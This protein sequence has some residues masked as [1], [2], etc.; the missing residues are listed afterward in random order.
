MGYLLT[1]LLK[2]GQNLIM[3]SGMHQVFSVGGI[4][5]LGFPTILGTS[6]YVLA[7]AERAGISPLVAFLLGVISALITGFFMAYLYA[8]MSNDSFV[9]LGLSSIIAFKA[10][11]LSGGE[12]TN[13]A[14]GIKGVLR[15][16]FMEKLLPLAIA[17]LIV[18]G[19]FWIIEYGIMSSWIGRAFRA[20]KED[21]RAVEA[22][23]ISRKKIDYFLI[24]YSSVLFSIGG[25]FML[26]HIQFLDPDFAHLELMIQLLT[27]GILALKPQLRYL[28][29]GV[30]FV[31]FVPELIRFLELPSDILGHLR[32]LIYS[33]T[34]M[35][36]LYLLRDKLTIAK[37]SF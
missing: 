26:W 21:A 16:E 35:G 7:I 1:L 24:I 29:F 13:G 15:P 28:F 17:T 33:L 18:A 30:T 25:M 31:V 8:K 3:G 11:A 19:L 6:V 4:F 9:V 20:N 23:G 27:I 37:R 2:F 14:R 36:F 34:L 10:L 32:I 12:L 5:F 22:L